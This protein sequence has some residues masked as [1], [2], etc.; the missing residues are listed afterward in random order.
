MHGGE[1]EC[2]LGLAR[3]PKR[4][5]PLGRHGLRWKDNIKMDI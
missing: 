1:A 3:K 4:E 5:I 2:K